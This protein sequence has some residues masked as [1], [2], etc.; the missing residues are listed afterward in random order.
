MANT[1]EL[2]CRAY[3]LR[4]IISAYDL[5]EID[6]F[7]DELLTEYYG[8]PQSIRLAAAESYRWRSYEM[9]PFWYRYGVYSPP[10]VYFLFSASDWRL[11]QPIDEIPF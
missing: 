2:Y 5:S 3:T 7:L 6:P 1:R 4:R 8:L 11:Q 10:K 9:L